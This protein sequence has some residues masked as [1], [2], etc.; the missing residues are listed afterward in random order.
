M[1]EAAT[2]GAVGYRDQARAWLADDPDADTRAELESLLAAG[3]DAALAERFAARLQFGTAGLRGELG[4]GPNRMNQALVR[5]AAA[6]LARYLGSGR[7]V[8]IGFDHR[9]KSEAFAHDS[10]AVMAAAGLHVALLPRPL[11]TPVLAFAIKHL[12]SDAGVMVTASH[13]PARDNGYKVYLGDGAQIVPPADQDISAAIDRVG[14]VST[15]PLSDAYRVLDDGVLEAYLEAATQ[16]VLCEGPRDVRIVY[17]PMHGVGRAV[18]VEALR[19]AGFSDVHVVVEQGEPDPAFPTV[20]FPNPEE[21]GALDLAHR[22]ARLVDA[23]LVVANDPDADRLAVAVG[24]RRLSGDEVGALLGHHL[25]STR[26]C[27]RGRLVVSSIVSSTL[28][29]R[30]ATDLGARSERTLTGFKWIVR[31]AL[32]HPELE[33]VLGYEEALGY[34]IGNLVRD[35]DG[36]SAALVVAELAASLKAEGRT[37]LDRLGDFDD[38][39]GRVRTAQRSFRIPPALQAEAMARVR[40]R[41]GAEDLRPRADVVVIQRG[42]DRVVFRPSGTE[43][44]LKLYT[45]V[46]DGDVDALQAEATAWAGLDKVDVP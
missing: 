43:P 42:T 1:S 17:T 16:L 21:P 35:K 14:T 45:E 10:A 25:L 24:D 41:R 32:A 5:R 7:R 20:A 6:G 12:S 13:N 2:A 19:R 44:K 8:V 33:F 40:D 34:T 46:V 38:R 28:L 22:D 23:D 31:P 30:I 15:I 4:A 3:D 11:P 36:I 18:A 26:P 27:E 9:D 37:L 29:E 39:Y